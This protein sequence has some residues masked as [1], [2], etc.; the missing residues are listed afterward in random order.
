[1]EN[2]EM[3]THTLLI[4]MQLLALVVGFHVQS[5]TLFTILPFYPSYLNHIAI[6]NN[7]L[8]LKNIS[9]DL[10]NKVEGEEAANRASSLPILL[11]HGKGKY[12]K[13]LII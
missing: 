11:C 5:L 6:F 8:S 7:N 13:N 1:M 12:F 4:W 10:S 9:R 2:L 3:E